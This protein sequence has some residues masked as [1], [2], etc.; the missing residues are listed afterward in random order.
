MSSSVRFN[1]VDE[2]PALRRYARVLTRDDALGED[3]VH[4]T[5]VRAYERR[6]TFRSDGDLRAWLFA[7]LHNVFVTDLRRSRADTA[8]H[9]RAAEVED[10]VRGPEQEHSVRLA[11]VQAAFSRLP[12]EQ[13][14][15]LHLVAVEGL[16]YQDAATALSIPLGT[17]MSRLGRARAALRSFEESPRLATSPIRLVGGT[18]ETR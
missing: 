9:H 5:L 15:V 3:L 13:R 10:R 1:V 7:I 11:Q 18:D 4:D 2:L 6:D 8:R 12:D 14:A 16:S 17:L